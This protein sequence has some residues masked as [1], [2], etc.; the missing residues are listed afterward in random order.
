MAVAT[1]ST[2]TKLKFVTTEPATSVAK[3]TDA[4]GPETSAS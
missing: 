1:G 2:T 4:V 3:R